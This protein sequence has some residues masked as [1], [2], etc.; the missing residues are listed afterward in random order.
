MWPDKEEH[1]EGY[2]DDMVKEIVEH[3]KDYFEDKEKVKAEWP[4][5][6]N[7]VF[8]AFFKEFETL[9]WQKV[10]RR[11]GN[12]YSHVLSLFDLI[13]SIPATSAACE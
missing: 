12:E 4:L 7:A 1:L 8:E 6:R 2:G 10:N 11:F 5:L 9:T 3:Y 13:L